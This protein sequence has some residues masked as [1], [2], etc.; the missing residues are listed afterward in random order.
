MQCM[1]SKNNSVINKQGFTLIEMLIVT[2]ILAVIS[3]AIYATFNNG[4]KIWQRVNKP[5]PGEGANIF[6]DKFAR[7]LRNTFKFTGLNFTGGQYRLEFVTLVN[8]PRLNNRTVGRVI[9]F[10]EPETKTLNRQQ[11][12]FS[13]IY[14]AEETAAQALLN[15]V[16]SLKFQYYLYNKEKKEYLWL[17]EWLRQDLPLAV[18]IE[19]ETNY[20]GH[21]DKFTKTVNIPVSG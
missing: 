4:I 11:Q 14:N 16:K 21:S 19:L 1:W 17:D 15:N 3:L 10:Y 12:D 13:Q 8:S 7:D 5:I 9:Y 20:G 2:A 18:R 6:F